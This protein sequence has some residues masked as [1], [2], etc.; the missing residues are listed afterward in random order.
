MSQH[1]DTSQRQILWLF[2]FP[3]DKYTQ[4]QIIRPEVSHAVEVH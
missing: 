4:M 2:F 3:F 1:K